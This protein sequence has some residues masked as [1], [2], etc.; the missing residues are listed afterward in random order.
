MAQ[1]KWRI[2]KSRGPLPILTP[3]EPWD[4][5]CED[6]AGQDGAPG[7]SG[8]VTVGAMIGYLADTKAYAEEMLACGGDSADAEAWESD[9]TVCDA[10]IRILSSL[11]EEGIHDAEQVL[12]LLYDY[13]LQARELKAARAELAHAAAMEQGAG[14]RTVRSRRRT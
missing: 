8:A 13:Q 14:K 1:K 2:G 12:D 11:E 7:P 10:A 3:L 9:V 5:R 6:D 4:G